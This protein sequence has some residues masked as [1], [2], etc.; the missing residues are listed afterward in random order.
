LLFALL[1]SAPALAAV[2][3]N[4]IITPQTPKL[5][6]AQFLP[7]STPGT[8]LTVYTAGASGSD[9]RSLWLDTNDTATHVVT[10]Q[11][12]CGASDSGC[13]NT[14]KY[15]GIT[16]TSTA[17]AGSQ[18]FALPQDMLT[19]AVWPG[20]MR[21]TDGNPYI[22][23]NVTDTLQCTYATAVTASDQVDI[24]AIGVDY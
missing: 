23:L 21:D 15:G 22:R 12:V 16:I 8:Y 5:G 13:T 18:A 4:N 1:F 11:I 20:L 14:L 7:A 6:L 3:P 9:I 19:P 10:C 2:T 24:H 17:G